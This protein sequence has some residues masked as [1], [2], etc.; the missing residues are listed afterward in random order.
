MLFAVLEEEFNMHK[1]QKLLD[2]V[3][4][5]GWMITKQLMNNCVVKAS[6]YDSKTLR[7]QTLHNREFKKKKYET[8]ETFLSLR[9]WSYMS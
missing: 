5:M 8:D 2:K 6:N 4:A 1:N 9:F 7:V 3:I